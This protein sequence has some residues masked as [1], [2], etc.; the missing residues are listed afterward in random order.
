MHG[1]L[2]SKQAKGEPTFAFGDDKFAMLENHKV[3]SDKAASAAKEEP[4]KQSKGGQVQTLKK[5][6]HC[7]CFSMVGDC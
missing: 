7:F 5:K 4:A 2:A 3:R 6:Q 1:I